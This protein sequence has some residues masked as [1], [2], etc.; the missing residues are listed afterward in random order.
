M[1]SHLGFTISTKKLTTETNTVRQRKDE[2]TAVHIGYWYALKSDRRHFV[3]V[4]GLCIRLQRKVGL[5][6]TLQSYIHEVLIRIFFSEL[7]LSRLRLSVG[8]PGP[9]RKCKDSIYD[10]VLPFLAVQS[11]YRQCPR[12][13]KIQLNTNLQIYIICSLKCVCQ[14]N[15]R[16]LNIMW[17]AA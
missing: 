8:F 14:L 11:R 1:V 16:K 15:I 4:T 5:P 12:I 6:L 2:R 10:H 9:P 3:E 17:R 7:H 13:K